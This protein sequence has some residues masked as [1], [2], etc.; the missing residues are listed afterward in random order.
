MDRL[1]NIIKIIN[2]NDYKYSVSFWTIGDKDILQ[3][4]IETEYYYGSI[5]NDKNISITR[6]AIENSDLE[7]WLVI[8]LTKEE[9][10][11]IREKIKEEVK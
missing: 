11:Y 7:E 1:E 9:I 10:K 3:N 5:Y 6:W 4:Y 8:G 2:S